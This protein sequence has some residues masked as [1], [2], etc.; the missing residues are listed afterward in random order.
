MLKR[1]FEII[2]TELFNLTLFDDEIPFKPRYHKIKN[3]Y[4]HKRK[5]YETTI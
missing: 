1:I 2:F 4:K 5:S 3:T